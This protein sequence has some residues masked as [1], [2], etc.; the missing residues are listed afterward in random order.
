M[1]DNPIG[2]YAAST[3]YASVPDDIYEATVTAAEVMMDKENPVLP[4]ADKFGKNRLRVKF[5]LDEEVGP[6]NG[7]IELNRQFAISYGAT[8]GTYAALASFIEATMGLK[9]GDKAQRN[10][11][12]S[13]LV[14]RKL[15]VQ[16]KNVE[17][18]DKTFCNVVGTFAPKAKS[19]A[20]RPAPAATHR[21]AADVGLEDADLEELPF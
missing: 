15:R 9:C 3:S 10:V 2:T 8:G 14:N 13:E 6:D 4:F 5:T 17:K 11:R 16:V 12:P 20:P 19:A 18:D 7:P 1:N 21:P